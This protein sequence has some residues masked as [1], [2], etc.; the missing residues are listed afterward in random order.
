MYGRVG[1]KIGVIL[2]GILLSFTLGESAWAQKLQIFKPPDFRHR[3]LPAEKSFRKKNTAL[4]RFYFNTVTRY[5]YI[6]NCE[7]IFASIME[8]ARDA[9]KDDYDELLSFYN[10]SLSFIAEKLRPQLDSI[11][12][13]TTTGILMRDLRNKWADD[14]YLFMG[15]AHYFRREY[16]SAAMIFQYINFHFQDD[17]PKEQAQTNSKYPVLNRLK[18]IQI[19]KIFNREQSG[20]LAPRPSARNDALLWLL[21]TY[22]EK[23]AWYDATV[24]LDKLQKDPILPARLKPFLEETVAYY[25]YKKGD[26]LQAAQHYA[27]SLPLSQDRQ[28]KARRSF[29]VAQLY[30]RVGRTDLAS[31]F[32]RGATKYTYD[33]VLEIYARMNFILQETHPNVNIINDHIGY[34][35]KLARQERFKRYKSLVYYAC[36]FMALK[37]NDLNQ[38]LDFIQT[39]SKYL[40][41]KDIHESNKIYARLFDLL[42]Q[43][44]QYYLAG[45]VLDSLHF[46]DPMPFPR[47][48]EFQEK[49]GYMRPIVALYAKRNLY[50]SLRRLGQYPEARLRA[51]VKDLAKLQ[52]RELELGAY[53]ENAQRYFAKFG[54]KPNGASYFSSQARVQAGIQ[55]FQSIWGNR[56]NVDHWRISARMGFVQRAQGLT[57]KNDTLAT[58]S[59]KDLEQRLL[60][61]IPRSPEQK[62]AN[63]SLLAESIFQLAE[64]IYLHIKDYELAAELYQD[65]LFGFPNF[66]EREALFLR[67][68]F[69]LKEA[70]NMKNSKARLAELKV[71]YEKEYPEGKYAQILGLKGTKSKQSETEQKQKLA[72]A[73]EQ[74]YA[75]AFQQFKWRNFPKCMKILDELAS[76]DKQGIFNNK[77]NLMRAV[78]ALGRKDYPEARKYLQLILSANQVGQEQTEEVLRL[79]AKTLLEHLESAEKSKSGAK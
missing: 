39:A 13:K 62:R 72:Q 34:M 45:Q 48:T 27:G 5:N 58:S 51:V 69:V 36:S 75:R 2:V 10:Y 74:T 67:L 18:H 49:Q 26:F 68:Y 77:A 53:K 21:R 15:Q 1:G 64:Q 76:A 8:L 56:K 59:S 42:W 73:L 17:K 14:L 22:I 63:D 31:K 41:K 24:L 29:F 7:R 19:D 79:R 28:E 55:E 11:L 46:P 52:K 50:D 66:P 70:Q 35:L 16:D 32:L 44:K 6:Y 57:N 65:L 9:H 47:A 37:K 30:N 71:R 4:R 43:K 60:A 54:A 25:Y 38:A 3:E 20:F 23:E 61:K 12:Q 33:P 40:S 78:Y